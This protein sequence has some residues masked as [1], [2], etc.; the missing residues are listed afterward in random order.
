ME[1][2]LFTI[3]MLFSLALSPAEMQQCFK[4]TD[5]VKGQCTFYNLTVL[6]PEEQVNNAIIIQHFTPLFS[7]SCSPYAR[8]L[9]CS[10][11]VPFCVSSHRQVQ[12]CRHLCLAV[13]SSCI[14]HFRTSN[15]PWPSTLNCTKLPSPPQVCISPP[16]S[17]TLPSPVSLPVSS[18]SAFSPS[19][20]PPS[21]THDVILAV[22]LPL[23]CLAVFLPLILFYARRLLF[24]RTQ[25]PAS[26]DASV[27]FT[28]NTAPSSPRIPATPSSTPPS[29]PQPSAT[30]TSTPPP[31]PPKLRLPIYQN[32]DRTTLYAVSDLF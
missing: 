11:F 25:P 15:M 5:L 30:P 7:S 4:V 23:L 27:I 13:K 14:H 10:T 18:S 8:I 1:S 17:P 6:S 19:L 12:P 3:L 2:T 21:S 28:P 26:N 16:L 22:S 32:T 29:S 9:V 20:S 24:P 31:L